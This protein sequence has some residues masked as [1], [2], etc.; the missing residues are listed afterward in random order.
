MIVVT[1]DEAGRRLAQG[2]GALVQ[3]TPVV[4][5]LTPG[6]ARV[7]GE[8]ARDLGAPL[9]I[10]AVCRLQVPGRDRSIF[11]AVADG[12]T[13][14]L[15]DRIREL[16]LPRAYV[17]ELVVLAQREVD[18]RSRVW[19][20]EA[21]PVS[22]N[23]RTVILA[24]DGQADPVSIV[25]AAT[26]IREGGAVRL[27]FAAPTACPETCRGLA[28]LI[29]ERVLLFGPERTGQTVVCDPRFAQTTRDDVPPILR[30]SRREFA[31]TGS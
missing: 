24:D 27:I 5:A 26:A 17:D 4:V 30:R 29:D 15:H 10:M 11:G 2:L 18:R 25:G 9:D 20:G 7:A 12:A 1:Q 14:L 16:D 3:E 8:I 19:R 31:V 28:G 23:G 22:L 21:P 13:L 6:A